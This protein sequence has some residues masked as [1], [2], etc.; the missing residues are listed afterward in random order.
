LKCQG[1]ICNWKTF[2]TPESNFFFDLRTVSFMAQKKYG[3]GK[4]SLLEVIEWAQNHTGIHGRTKSIAI[5]PYRLCPGIKR[6]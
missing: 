2:N 5:Y 1:Q 3:F 4:K 6:A